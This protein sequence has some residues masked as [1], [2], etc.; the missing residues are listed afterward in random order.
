MQLYESRYTSVLCDSV[1]FFCS[2]LIFQCDKQVKPALLEV[3]DTGE[4]M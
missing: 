2:V 3:C 4:K 1:L